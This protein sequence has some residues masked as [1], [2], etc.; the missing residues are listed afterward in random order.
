MAASAADDA[1]LAGPAAD[2]TAPATEQGGEPQGFDQVSVSPRILSKSAVMPL[3]A[4]L[5]LLALPLDLPL[6]P[7]L[8]PPLDPLLDPPLDL[9]LAP[10]QALLLALLLMMML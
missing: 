5:P 9:P 2:G 4:Q 8:D 1:T 7:L 10:L 6:A 3:K